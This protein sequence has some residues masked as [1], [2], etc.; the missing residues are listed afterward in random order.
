MVPHN[1]RSGENTPPTRCLRLPLSA[2]VLA[3]ALVI[4]A[5]V[6]GIEDALVVA[7]AATAVAC[8]LVTVCIGVV[9]PVDTTG[10]LFRSRRGRETRACPGRGGG[11][12]G[13]AASIA[14]GRRRDKDQGRSARR[15]R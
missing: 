9:V 8:V 1:L 3:A 2:M 14:V 10:G 6:A 13:G 12:K 5:N 15:D 4:A 7:A 11:E